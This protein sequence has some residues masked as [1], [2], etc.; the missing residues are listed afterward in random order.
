[1]VPRNSN[2]ITK[3]KRG[4]KQRRQGDT[5]ETDQWVGRQKEE[6]EGRAGGT[7][8]TNEASKNRRKD[9]TDGATARYVPSCRQRQ[10]DRKKQQKRRCFATKQIKE[11]S[12]R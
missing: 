8:N 9:P 3:T 4:I 11:K 2:D 10:D 5:R 1:M 6:T 7:D 12:M